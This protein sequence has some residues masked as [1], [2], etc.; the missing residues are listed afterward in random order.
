MAQLT[1]VANIVAKPDKVELVKSE[2]INLIAFTRNENGC[3]NYD[4]HQDNANPAMFIF[5]E[6]W[7]SRDLW[8]KHMSNSHIAKYL[9][10]TEGAVD[11]FIV[12][13]MTKIG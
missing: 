3:V 4:L 13:E 9:S 7:L 8:Q 10:A 2:L 1:I 6:N 11:S 12:H 5:Y